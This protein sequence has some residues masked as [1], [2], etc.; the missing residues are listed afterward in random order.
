MSADYG[1]AA[2]WPAPL[3]GASLTALALYLVARLAGPKRLLSAV[4]V[5]GF[6]LLALVLLVGIV[7]AA[8]ARAA[9]AW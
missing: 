2:W 5:A 9:V 3:L 1:L 6:A 8:F 7:A 4:A